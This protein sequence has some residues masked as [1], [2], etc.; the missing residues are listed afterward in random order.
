MRNSRLQNQD[1]QTS[2]S[3]TTQA[4]RERRWL[5]AIAQKDTSAS[6]HVVTSSRSEALPHMS[7]S[8]FLVLSLN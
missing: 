5:Q 8:T 2:L 4:F 7:K 6:T 3:Q 1:H